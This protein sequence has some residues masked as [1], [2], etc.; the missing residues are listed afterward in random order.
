[1][2]YKDATQAVLEGKVDAAII[3][4]QA[5]LM[6]KTDNLTWFKQ[7]TVNLLWKNHPDTAHQARKTDNKTDR[8]VV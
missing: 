6:R 4:T 7:K 5:S 1:M 8:S 2:T 3:I